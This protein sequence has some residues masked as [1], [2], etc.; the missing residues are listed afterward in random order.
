MPGPNDEVIPILGHQLVDV[1]CIVGVGGWSAGLHCEVL[2][3]LLLSQFAAVPSP[4]GHVVT[5]WH[6][7]QPRAEGLGKRPPDH[8]RLGHGE[9]E[10]MVLVEPGQDAPDGIDIGVVVERTAELVRHHREVGEV[11]GRRADKADVSRMVRA[12]VLADIL[13]GL[14]VG[15][16][17]PAVLRF[18]EPDDLAPR[19]GRDVLL[20]HDRIPPGWLRR[21]GRRD[22]PHHRHQARD[23]LPGH[24][25]LPTGN[26]TPMG[27]R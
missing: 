20:D 3:S 5:L 10:G 17:L 27:R 7:V 9:F 19:A 13:G 11:L 23:T 12:N 22:P 14:V 25:T 6:P 2:T 15:K 24:G 1:S 8:D 26:A 21:P 16:R 4:L 18:K